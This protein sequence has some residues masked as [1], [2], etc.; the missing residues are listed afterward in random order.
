MFSTNLN[1]IDDQGSKDPISGKIDFVDEGEGQSLDAIS[2]VEEPAEEGIDEKSDG[3]E[4]KDS[5]DPE[6]VCEESND[7]KRSNVSTSKD[8]ETSD[9]K[10]PMQEPDAADDTD[11]RTDEVFEDD[12]EGENLVSEVVKKMM[13]MKITYD[14]QVDATKL[15]FKLKHA[16][17]NKIVY[18]I[19]RTYQA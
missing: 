1:L 15:N 13:L 18:P 14:L 6:V 7:S 10:N 11:L 17:K 2:S 19:C 12:E 8:K 5:N 3:N 4:N 16:N 9:D